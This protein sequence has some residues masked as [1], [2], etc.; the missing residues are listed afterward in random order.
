M[1]MLFW[2]SLQ[3]DSM[4]YLV[5]PSL[6]E[7]GYFTEALRQMR[8]VVNFHVAGRRDSLDMVSKAFQYGNYMKVIEL[9]RFV[10]HCQR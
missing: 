9:S 5:L 10:D 8:S 7:A 6:L 1:R 2:L 4:S 3:H